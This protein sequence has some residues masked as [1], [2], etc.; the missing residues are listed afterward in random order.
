MG[1]Q[2]VEHKLNPKHVLQIILGRRRA[3]AQIVNIPGVNNTINARVNY[4]NKRYYEFLAP[5]REFGE[6]HKY[7]DKARARKPLKK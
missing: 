5:H 4:L 1:Q 2:F 3:P 6:E 7:E